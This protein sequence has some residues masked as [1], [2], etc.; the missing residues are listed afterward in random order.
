MDIFTRFNRNKITDRQIDTM[1]GLTMGISAD[2]KIDQTEAAFLQAWLV[3]NSATENPL[4]LNLLAK[5]NAMLEDGV[6]D[7]EESK[8]LLEL[9]HKFT[10][11]PTEIDEVSKTSTLPICIPAPRV[12]FDGK[13]F[14]FTGTF[15][16]GSRIQ[17]QSL[18]ESL[19]GLNAK[20]VTKSVNFLVLGTYVTDSW[21]HESFG[22][23]IEKAVEYR[24]SGVPLAIVTEGHWLEASGV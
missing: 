3:K 20:N 4:I 18:V 15:A 12:I 1:L 19:G 21:V 9:L 8:E 5:V 16:Y 6:L 2:G 11:E 24:E 13:Q 7:E 22:R 23:K 10:G 14:L 17:C